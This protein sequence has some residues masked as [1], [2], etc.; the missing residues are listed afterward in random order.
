MQVTINEIKLFTPERHTKTFVY[1]SPMPDSEHPPRHCFQA[2]H[3]GAIAK[4]L[5]RQIMP[6][7][8]ITSASILSMRNNDQTPTML[9]HTK[10]NSI[11]HY[12]EINPFAHEGHNQGMPYK[13]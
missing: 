3:H 13:C 5:D 6:A 12:S 7:P 4:G 10:N 2:P 1:V 11:Q 9:Y 8:V